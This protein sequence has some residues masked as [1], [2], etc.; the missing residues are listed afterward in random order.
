M[1][2]IKNTLRTYLNFVDPSWKLIKRFFTL[3]MILL[4]LYVIMVLSL[5]L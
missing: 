1:Q 4:L 2:P 3:L 5:I